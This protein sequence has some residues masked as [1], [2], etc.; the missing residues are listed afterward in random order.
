VPG[1][2]LK[3]GAPF[4]A[5]LLLRS[6]GR[7]VKSP[8]SS[9]VT[10]ANATSQTVIVKSV[11]VGMASVQVQYTLNNRV[12]S[13]TQNVKVQRPTSLGVISDVSSR[14]DCGAAPYNGSRREILYQV[15]DGSSPPQPIP[16]ANM[17]VAETLSVTANSC[18][19][20][21]PTP[22]SGATVGTGN[23]PGPDVLALCSTACL[24]ADSNRNP[25]GS[26]N[27]TVN[28]TWKAK[29]F[30]VRTN[31][32]NYGCSSIGVTPQ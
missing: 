22:T 15:Q 27:I 16:V 28:Q 20:A 11:A 25:L 13:A 26:C 3:A 17:S 8:A 1:T 6:E 14:P 29:G 9:N 30:V 24:P 23:F 10:L 5:E 32:L 19:V 2:V 12:G 7:E 21:N 18:N 4:F 31:V